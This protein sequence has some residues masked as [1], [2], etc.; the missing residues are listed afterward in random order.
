MK[1]QGWLWG[2]LFWI[3]ATMASTLTWS[4]SGDRELYILD[5]GGDVLSADGASLTLQSRPAM[6]K[7]DGNGAGV[8]VID[9]RPY[10]QQR[11]RLSAEVGTH[12]V[13][14]VAGIWLRADAASGVVSFANSQ[15]SPVSGDT[16]GA[17]RDIEIYVPADADR[18]LVGPLLM[19]SGR[20]SVARLRLERAP[21][22]S[23][24]GIT[25]AEI[26]DAAFTKTRAHALNAD[27][28]DWDQ[29]RRDVAYEMSQGHT[30]EAAYGAI[31]SLLG[32]LQD[33][34]SGLIPPREFQRLAEE[35][36]PS[37]E[38]AVE[39]RNAVCIVAVPSFSGTDQAAGAAFARDLA[40]AIATH[41]PAASCGWVV[42]L[43]RNGGG[44]MWPMLSGLHPLLGEATPGYFRDR[45]G[46]QHA[47]RLRRPDVQAPDLSAVPV[48]VATGARTASSGEAVAVAFRG[49]PHTRSV[50]QPTA[51]VSTSNQ[52]FTL[53]G[54]A[55]LNLTT[56]RFVDRTGRAYGDVLVPDERV[57][58]SDAVARA[59]ASLAG[60]RR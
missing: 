4:V 28:V 19:G 53:P 33:R 41:A 9:A 27:L 51:G 43:S 55:R 10:R 14:G 13:E 31:R 49:R 60:C 54:G 45:E 38:P 35:G 3:P 8:A 34:H 16:D 50:G 15:R 22:R 40:S 1:A 39:V 48:V 58:E 17:L 25:P 26:V 37:F 11:V 2:L 30:A 18:L 12:G 29:A 46:H 59:V 20:M 24:D 21:P 36:K 57:P 23:D 56:A 7:G 42:D 44:N 5:G 6:M 47:W 32:K 52:M